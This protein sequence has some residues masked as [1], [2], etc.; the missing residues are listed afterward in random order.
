MSISDLWLN[1]SVKNIENSKAFFTAIGFE[2]SE[3]PGNS[4]TS[5]CILMGTK[6]VVVMLFQE[7]VFNGFI[8]QKGTFSSPHPSLISISVDSKE[9]VDSLAQKVI[10]AGGACSHEPKEMKDW[11]YACNFLDL[12]QHQWNVVYM[13][14]DTV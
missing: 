9:A 5:A 1:L 12:D 7:E 14:N 8:N 13:K 2:L 10:N 3:G 11:I 4:A 6:K